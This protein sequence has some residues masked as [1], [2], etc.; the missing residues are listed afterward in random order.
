MEIDPANLVPLARLRRNLGPQ[1]YQLSLR[2]DGL[3][4]L[5]LPAVL[6][7]YEDRQ[8][9]GD[10]Q[11][12]LRISTRGIDPQAEGELRPAR[13]LRVWKHGKKYVHI[14]LAEEE[15][16]AL[17]RSASQTALPKI[18]ADLSGLWLCASQQ[19]LK[20]NFEEPYFFQILGL[21]VTSKGRPV[22]RVK[23]YFETNAHGILVITLN[24]EEGE[25]PDKTSK[26]LM[27]PCVEEHVQWDE[28]LDYIEVPHFESFLEAEGLKL[29]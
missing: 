21:K 2:G 19:Q 8:K 6:Y 13:L 9:S 5:D 14:E 27:L 4:S 10:F 23:D 3:Y 26:E 25:T 20:T 7:L 12:I 11:S 24:T 17:S 28:N 1:I 22:A 18:P 16:Q 29:P 15:N